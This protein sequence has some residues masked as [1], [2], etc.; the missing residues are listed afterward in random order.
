MSENNEPLLKYNSQRSTAALF[1]L[2]FKAVTLLFKV[3]YNG[4]LIDILRNHLIS[5]TQKWF[6]DYGHIHGR[7][8]STLQ[9]CNIHRIISHADMIN[10]NYEKLIILK[11]F[12]WDLKSCGF[13]Y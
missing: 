7:L 12:H 9:T 1:V 6:D 3:C 2:H 8:V 13:P 10:H 4:L 5:L 11:I